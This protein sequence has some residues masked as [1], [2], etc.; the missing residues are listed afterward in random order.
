MLTIDG[1]MLIGRVIPENMI[2]STLHKLDAE[3][4]KGSISAEDLVKGIK[5]GDT[6]HLDNGWRITQRRVSNEQRIEIMGADYLYS[7]LLTKKGVFT[8]RIAHQTRYFIPS[9]KDTAKILDDVIKISP[10]SRVV[11]GNERVAAKSAAVP[12]S[13]RAASEAPQKIPEPTPAKRPRMAE[14][15]ARAQARMAAA[16]AK[17]RDEAHSGHITKRKV[18]AR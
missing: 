6:V 16:E 4:K 17:R 10:V 5:N 15:Y 18:D 8:E 2:D 13:Y 1:D 7:D 3:R 9:E 12:L 11:S 14:L